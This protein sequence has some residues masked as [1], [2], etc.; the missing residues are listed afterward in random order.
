MKR[1]SMIASGRVQGV[2]FRAYVQDIACGMN[3]NGWVRNLPDGTVE[4]EAEGED[5]VVNRLI[6]VIRHSC[7]T[8]IQVDALRTS[9]IPITREQGFFVRR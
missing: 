6:Q 2:G 1:V 4:I 9:D 5:A 7:S 8:Y 3:L